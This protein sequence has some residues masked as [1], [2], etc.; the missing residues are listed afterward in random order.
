MARTGESG[1]RGHAIAPLPPPRH[2]GSP[3]R[4]PAWRITCARYTLPAALAPMHFANPAGFYALLALPVI[5]LIHSLQERSRRLRVSTLFLLERIAPESVSGSR[6]ERWRQSLPFWMQMLA[7]V[8]LAWV[9]AQ[10]RWL[11]QDSVQTVVL[12]MD[13]SASMS[14]F[15]NQT[16]SELRHVLGAWSGSAAHTRWHAIESDPRKPTLFT[17]AS[18]EGLLAALDKFRPTKGTHDISDALSTARGLLRGGDGTIIFVTDH[19]VSLPADISV[20]AVGEPSPNAGWSGVSVDAPFRWTALLTNHSEQTQVRE[21][22]I[23]HDKTTSPTHA[24]VTIE[25]G[26]TLSLHGELPDDVT[27]ATLCLT[28]D[29]FPLDDRA[30]MIRPRPVPVRISVRTAGESGKLVQSMLAALDGVNFVKT[31]EAADLTVAEI[32]EDSPTDAILL[33]SDAPT[34][35]KLDP[36]LVVAEH[37]ALTEDLTWMGLLCARPRQLAVLESDVP[38]LWRNNEPLALLRNTSSADGKA[39]RQLMLNWDIH[40]SNASRLPAMVVMLQRFVESVRAQIPGERVINA[41]CGQEIPLPD[42]VLAGT[43]TAQTAAGPQPF[44]G[45]APDEPGFFQVMQTGTND[46][47][48]RGAAC[49]A[50]ARESDL[51]KCDSYDGT[52]ERRKETAMRLTEADPLTPL[53]L[54]GVLACLLTAWGSRPGAARSASDNPAAAGLRPAA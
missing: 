5:V 37:H 51:T 14:A 27:Q 9:L 2:H 19:R 6:L 24:S 4:I 29:A 30:P 44:R 8:L 16:R 10:P 45:S 15:P 41:D 52:G 32:G 48:L 3:R 25:P 50:D 11:R 1:H 34:S 12:V 46:A 31:D 49:F 53:W 43:L 17:G 18:V 21:W 22:W 39:V 35:A 38:L 13:S 54:L 40:H 7:A 36:S 26:R 28:S 47:A 33:D 23:E 42:A 20:L